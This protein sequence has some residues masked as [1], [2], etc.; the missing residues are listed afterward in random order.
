MA[1]I[2]AKNVV[3]KRKT[4]KLAIITHPSILNILNS[5]FGIS[6]GNGLHAFGQS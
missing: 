4:V 1:D 3:N 2:V 5:L 6:G